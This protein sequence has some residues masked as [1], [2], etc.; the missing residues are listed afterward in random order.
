M[1]TLGWMEGG[2][3]HDGVEGGVVVAIYPPL[4]V[5]V[6]VAVAVEQVVHLRH[7][8]KHVRLVVVAL[9][10]ALVPVLLQPQRPLPIP[11]HA[12]STKL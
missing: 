4:V 8:R 7:H 2:S 5:V 6:V 3:H 12:P 1:G 10:Q 9:H 11:P